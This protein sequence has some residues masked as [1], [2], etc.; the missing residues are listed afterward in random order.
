MTKKDKTPDPRKNYSPG[1]EFERFD[2]APGR[3]CAYGWKD[4]RY[5]KPFITQASGG[6]SQHICIRDTGQ[7]DAMIK[8][9]LA[10]RPHFDVSPQEPKTGF[11]K[12]QIE[13]QVKYNAKVNRII[14]AMPKNSESPR[15]DGCCVCGR[16]TRH[17]KDCPERLH[18][19]IE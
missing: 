16:T 3:Y 9:L 7:I 4:P 8:A 14:D 19:K 1:Y 17:K 2:I 12:I 6:V 5:F 18:D 15:F 13:A 10:L 11:D